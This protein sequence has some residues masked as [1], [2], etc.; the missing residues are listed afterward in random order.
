MNIF[1]LLDNT[2]TNIF[3]PVGSLLL[4]IYVGWVAP[5]NLLID[6]LSNGGTLRSRIYPAVLAIVR[7]VAP[8]L[9]AAVLVSS[10]L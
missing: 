10:F 8:L 7:Y 4:C 3:L 6:Q 5:R 1:D 9:I 2:A